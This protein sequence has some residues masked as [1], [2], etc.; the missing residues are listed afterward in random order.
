MTEPTIADLPHRTRFA[1]RSGPLLALVCAAVF[2]AGALAQDAPP[3]AGMRSDPTA[4][5][6]ESPTGVAGKEAAA[7]VPRPADGDAA[8]LAAEQGSPGPMTAYDEDLRHFFVL[9][10]AILV[11][12]PV[13]A[14][15]A[16]ILRRRR[17]RDD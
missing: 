5:S 12:R 14:M 15:V 10:L 16:A 17:E 8:P 1:V 13:V 3:S 11:L 6:G 2:A 9:L 4:H 7:A